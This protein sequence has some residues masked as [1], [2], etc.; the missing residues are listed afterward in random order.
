MKQMK[1]YL[2][3]IFYTWYIMLQSI[4]G[5]IF[6]NWYQDTFKVSEGQVDGIIA[7][8]VIMTLLQGIFMVMLWRAAILQVKMKDQFG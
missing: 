8:C 1:Q 7:V 4:C 3:A 2:I 5:P 6:F